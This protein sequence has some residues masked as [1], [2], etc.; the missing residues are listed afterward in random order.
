ME[1]T[2][3]LENELDN[4]IPVEVSKDFDE[5]IDNNIEEYDENEDTNEEKKE[6]ENFF[7]SNIESIWNKSIIKKPKKKSRKKI[8][9]SK[10]L[11]E[12]ITNLLGQ[13][14]I[15]YVNGQVDECIPLLSDIIK[16]KP[17][18]SEPYELLA[19]IYDESD[20]KLLALQFYVL[21]AMN[22]KKRTDL[23]RDIVI[24]AY[25]LK[26]YD[27]ALSAIA[28]VLRVDANDIDMHKA[29][30]YIYLNQKKFHKA[31]YC[32]KV[33]IV[34]LPDQLD[35]VNEFVQLC[36]DNY[37]FDYAVRG[38][39]IYLSFYTGFNYSKEIVNFFDLP[40]LTFTARL[41]DKTLIY[42]PKCTIKSYQQSFRTV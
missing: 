15:L 13:I 16:S 9:Y 33:L 11:G 12:D 27:Q 39:L 10:R 37:W 21:E 34:K 18:L 41:D 30:I 22:T 42:Q 40:K 31:W 7:Q 5:T 28:R 20:N 38:Y 4:F 26:Q 24:R 19:Q 14:N 32:L 6:S 17:Y 8:T 3:A 29:R 36:I 23:W 25:E 2:E 35:A 1:I